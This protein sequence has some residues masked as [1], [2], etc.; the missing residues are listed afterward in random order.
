MGDE[1]AHVSRYLK[2]QRKIPV[3]DICTGRHVNYLLLLLDGS[4]GVRCYSE[5]F[6]KQF[7]DSEAHVIVILFRSKLTPAA[8]ADYTQTSDAL[9]TYVKTMPGFLDV[10]SFRAEDGERLTVVWWKDRETLE[11][12]RTDSRHLSAKQTG[13]ERWYEY[14]NLEVA[15]IVRAKQFTRPA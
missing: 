3:K 5:K 7:S 15:E 12:W 13:R 14:Y 10:K 8:G 11:Q 2:I 6:W 1:L 4:T 9:E